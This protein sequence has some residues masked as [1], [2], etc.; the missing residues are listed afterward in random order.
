M[1]TLPYLS[2]TIVQRSVDHLTPYDR[3]ART[4]SRKQVDQIVRSIERFGF[5]NPLLIDAQNRLLAGHGRLEAARKLGMRE[6][7]CV[8]L[9][10]LSSAE[11]RAY[12][13][14]DNKLALNAGWD[15]E[16]LASEMQELLDGNFDLEITGFSLAEIDLTIEAS[17][18]ARVD[19]RP[20]RGDVLPP[21]GRAAVA[22]AGDCWD[23]GR[24]RLVCGS[25]LE[26]KTYEQLLGGDRVDMVFT[27]PPY[28]VPIAGHVSGLGKVKHRE[29]AMASGEMTSDQFTAFLAQALGCAKDRS[30]DGA[31]LFV[32]MDWRHQRELLAAAD[33]LQLEL[34]NICVWNKLRGGMGTFYRSQHE[35]VFVLKHGDAPHTNSF[36]LGETGRSRTNMWDYRGVSALNAVGR[37]VLAM[38]PT[39]KPVALVADAIR[40]CSRRGEIILDGFGGSGST[41]IAAHQTG[42]TARLI[43]LDPL[44]CDV[45][46]RRFEMVTGKQATLEGRTFEDVAHERCQQLEQIHG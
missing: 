4:H 14:A 44:Y 30:K 3:N 32:C 1:K 46:L 7:P 21:I 11:R 19:R 45:I 40:D 33:A 22:R 2:A 24:H 35:F 20:D 27:D 28:N 17:E 26:A 23:L 16:L 6:V 10:H 18:N 25:A 13:L 42:R 12:I 41:L 9:P 5:T 43:E 38:H 37:D 34:K 8:E 15:L 36:G 39:V 31:I 29:F